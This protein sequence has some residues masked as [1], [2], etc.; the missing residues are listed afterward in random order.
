MLNKLALALAVAIVVLLAAVAALSISGSRDR[1]S[2]NGD[3]SEL[4]S[5]EEV[6]DARTTVAMG[7]AG[8]PLDI[9]CR[10]PGD[11]STPLLVSFINATSATDDYL[12]KITVV[13]TTGRTVTALAEAT[14]LR[15][16]ER[17][18]VVPEPWPDD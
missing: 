6:V 12:A 1:A 7:G 5:S 10:I 18:E 17:R 16:G 14:A 13:Y 9:E 15:P 2:E 8:Q 3:D 4:V 11:S